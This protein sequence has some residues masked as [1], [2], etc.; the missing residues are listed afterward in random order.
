MKERDPDL[1]NV[2]S[3]YG[4]PL[5]REPEPGF[6]ALVQIILEQQVSL[7]SA[8][9]TFDRLIQS[10]PI[11]TAAEFLRLDRE[12]LRHI[13]FSRQKTR[14]GR[15]L[16]S[17]VIEGSLPLESI[18]T[19]DDDQA[20]EALLKITGIGPWTADIYLLT[21]LL[22]P[23]IWPIGDLALAVS[24]QRIKKLETRPSLKELESLGER[25]KPWRAVAARIFWHYYLNCP[26]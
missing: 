23:D 6:P 11:L 17:A 10:V 3:S 16:A 1:G 9:A 26:A 25:W 20:R 22:R 19:M 2:L 21:V 15:N 24:V 18:E 13:G 12:M 7:A 5:M 4:P 8:K 14:Y